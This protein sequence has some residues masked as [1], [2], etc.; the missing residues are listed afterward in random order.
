MSS[1]LSVTDH[2]FIQIV[3][4]FPVLVAVHKDKAKIKKTRQTEYWILVS[5]RMVLPSSIT[6][7]SNLW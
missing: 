2:A 4:T 3:H 1:G 6:S 7:M 5:Y